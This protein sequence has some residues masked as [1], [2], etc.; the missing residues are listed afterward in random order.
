MKAE[1]LNWEGIKTFQLAMFFCFNLPKYLVN[2]I[3]YITEVVTVEVNF[4]FF[5]VPQK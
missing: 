5:T 3:I 4:F 1:L 2:T